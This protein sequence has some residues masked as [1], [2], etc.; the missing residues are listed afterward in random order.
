[1][2]REIL[3]NSVAFQPSTLRTL[4]SAVDLL[5]IMFDKGPECKCPIPTTSVVLVVDDDVLSRRAVTFGLEKARLKSVGTADPHH[6]LAEMEKNSFELV[7]LD[8]DMPDMDGFELCTRIR[9]LP[10]YAKTPVVF[11][12]GM[13]DFQTRAKS[14]TSGG[15]DFISKPLCFIEL[16]VKALTFVLKGRLAGQ[17]TENPHPL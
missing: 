17:E 8:V 11:I 2:L 7:F 5:G 15:N 6:A 10:A 12:T 4:A 3:L 1:M 9:R 16:A 13:T 14:I